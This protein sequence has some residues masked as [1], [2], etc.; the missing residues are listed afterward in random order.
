MAASESK[1]V[2]FGIS[3][4]H[5]AVWNDDTSTYG[6][7]V[8]IPGAVKMSL[9]R[10]G[11][12]DTFHADNMPYATFMTNG[13]YTGELE[14]AYGPAQMLVDLL[15]Y[16]KDSQGLVIEDAKA[17]APSF[18]ILYEVSS[19]KEDERFVFYECTMSRPENEANTKTDSTNPDTQT[20]EF[21]AIPHQ[22]AYGS[23]TVEAV[24]AFVV[25]DAEGKTAY[26]SFF[27]AVLTPKAS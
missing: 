3:N 10:E 4:V 20:F 21:T 27:D 15:G 18:A 14:M 23:D 26:E 24:K 19:N 22:F 25:N 7:P 11:S 9:T 2:V 5:Y 16:K 17:K 6:T 12:S 13:G 8:H 1:K